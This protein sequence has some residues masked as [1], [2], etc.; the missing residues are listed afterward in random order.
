MPQG[1]R[2]RLRSQTREVHA[3]LDATIARMFEDRVGYGR[4]LLGAFSARARLEALLAR[5]P[6]TDVFIDPIR[7]DLA[8]DLNDVM[9]MEQAD[10]RAAID[11]AALLEAPRAWGVGYVLSG[12][13]LGAITL[14]KWAAGLGFSDR[15]G[16]RH[17][18]VQVAGVKS[19]PL[20]VSALEALPM[21]A[22]EEAGCVEGAM[23]AFAMFERALEMPV[24]A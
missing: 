20:F 24:D 17:L 14:Q 19:W 6:S 11:I 8:A 3:R 1:L 12:S 5:C 7:D 22:G 18:A 9:P 13:A 16:A 2:F 10:R 21:S 15:F 4:Y 23:L